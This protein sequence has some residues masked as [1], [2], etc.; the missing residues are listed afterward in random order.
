[1]RKIKSV[2][3]TEKLFGRLQEISCWAEGILP[4]Y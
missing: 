3:Q 2:W 4:Q 1:M